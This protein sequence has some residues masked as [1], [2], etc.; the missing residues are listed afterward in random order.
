MSSFKLEKVLISDACDPSVVDILKSRD[1][2]CDIKTGLPKEQLI[3]TIK[4]YD[5]L[6]VR[7][8]TQV[9]ADVIAAGKKLKVIGRAGVGVDNIDVQAAKQLGVSVI[10]A[11]GGNSISAAE[12]TCTMLLSVSRHLAQACASLKNG[13]WDRKSFSGNEVY[14]KTLAIIGLGRIGREVA[15]RMQA[16]GM[17]TIGFDPLV[18]AETSQTFGVETVA[19]DKLWPLADYITVHTPLIPQTKNLLNDTTIAQCKKGVRIVNV[20]RGGIVDEEALLRGLQSG[21]VGGAGLDVYEE[22][23]PSRSQLIGHPKVICTPHLGASTKEAQINVAKEIAYQFIDMIDGK[24]V[25]G[26]V[27]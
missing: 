13:V 12:L 15:A 3:D 23:P 19:L 8:N 2:R 1:I 5:A 7:S 16:F 17:K 14:G 9:T 11:P 4:D 21:Q 27:C 10:N 6:I 18:S 25:A 22:E 26:K 24:P 20:A